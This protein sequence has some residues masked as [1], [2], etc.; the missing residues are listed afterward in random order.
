MIVTAFSRKKW[1]KP[2]E[3]LGLQ[4]MR[5]PR[6]APQA[7]A[8]CERFIGRM[9]REC[10]DFTIPF[11]ERRLKR[12]LSEWVAH[13]NHARPHRSPGPGLPVPELLLR[14]SP[15]LTVI[16]CPRDGASQ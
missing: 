14:S 9:R 6:R 13:Y 12:I 4:V 11:N 8:Y 1:I 2:I 10:L 3:N 15:K 16:N 7:N 5:T